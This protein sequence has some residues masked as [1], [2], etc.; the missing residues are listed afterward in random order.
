LFGGLFANL[1]ERDGL[2]EHGSNDGEAFS[3][4][5]QPPGHFRRSFEKPSFP[6]SQ[7]HFAGEKQEVCALGTEERRVRPIDGRF[8]ALQP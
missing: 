6:A 8:D 5:A 2:A 3:K 1:F 7:F 4:G